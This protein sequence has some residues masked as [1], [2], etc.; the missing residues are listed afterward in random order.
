MIAKFV[1]FCT[2]HN[3]NYFEPSIE[4]VCAYTEKLAQDFTS[5]KSVCNYLGAMKLMHKFA[6]REAKSMDSFEMALMVRAIK[7]T[8]RT[9]PNTRKAIV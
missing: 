8:M 6:G 1:R 3:V 4:T 9:I 7:L 2:T 5:P